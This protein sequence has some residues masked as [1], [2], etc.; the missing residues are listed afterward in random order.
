MKINRRAVFFAISLAF[1]IR[2][3]TWAS[4]FQASQT[5]SDRILV[6]LQSGPNEVDIDGDGRNDLILTA[7]RD[8]ANAHGYDNVTFYI[9]GEGDDSRWR[10]MPLFEQDERLSSDSFR[11]NQGADCQLRNMAVLRNP[12]RTRDPLTLIVGEREFGKSYVD[13]AAVKFVVY[14]IVHARDR[15]PGWPDVYFRAER[16]ID[17]KSK[18]CDV[19][20]AFA[21]E[22]GIRPSIAGV[23]TSQ[24]RPAPGGEFVLRG[25]ISFEGVAPT[26]APISMRADPKCPDRQFTTEDVLVSDG[27]LEN[28][29]VFVS[30]PVSGSFP[31]NKETTVLDQRNCLYQPHVMTLRV[32]QPL[33]VRN[34]DDT[35][36]NIHVLATGNGNLFNIAQPVRGAENIKTFATPE[37]PFALKD[38]V[39]PWKRAFVGVF[40]HP[41]HTV[42]GRGGSYQ[43]N[44]PP[45]SYEITAWH[46]KLGVQKQSVSVDDREVFLNFTFKQ[47]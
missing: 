26:P 6:P 29:M 44:L 28:V 40:S 34:S 39:H 47:P 42:T 27:G 2:M 16:T 8:N 7:W 33:M 43:L 35:A 18:Y 3:A 20:E 12:K 21:A 25:K 10:I 11:T 13:T 14:E 31:E 22:L 24:S 46:E 32:G 41:F 5:F 30:S 15:V 19:N 17:A 9:R 38:D 4:P 45:G 23:Q 37:V 1:A 36:H